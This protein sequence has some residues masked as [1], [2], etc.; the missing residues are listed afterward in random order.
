MRADKAGAKLHARRAHFQIGGDCAAAADAACDEHRNLVRDFG[1]DFLREHAGRHRTDM[2]ACLHPLDHQRIDARTDE[3]LGERQ[4]GC[5][6]HDLGAHLLDRLD[7]ALGRQPACQHDM[8]DLMLGAHR[9]QLHQLRVHGDEVDAERLGSKR[10]GR[11]DLGIEQ[12]GGHRPAGNHAKAACI[13]DGRD[14][15]ALRHPAHRP[16]KDRGLA[17]QKGGAARHGGS[18]ERVVHAQASTA[19]SPYAVCS[20]RTASSV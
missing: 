5:E 6:T 3:L 8:A 9:D 2:A 10:L 4:R 15:I 1:Q 7:A 17:A 12:F 20:T 11:G 19:S 14:E 13:R 16:A 18:G